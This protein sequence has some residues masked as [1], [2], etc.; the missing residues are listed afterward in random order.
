MY[1][2]TYFSPRSYS[3]LLAMSDSLFLGMTCPT[4]HPASRLGIGG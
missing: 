2:F 1:F 4:S 3:V